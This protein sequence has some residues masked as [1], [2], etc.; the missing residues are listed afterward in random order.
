MALSDVIDDTTMDASD[1]QQIIGLLK[2]YSGF[3]DR[4]RLISYSN[5]SNYSLEVKNLDSGSKAVILYDSAGNV[6]LQANSSGV[7]LS[8]DGTNFGLTPATLSGTETLTNKTLTA[9]TITAPTF[10]RGTSTASAASLTLPTN[11]P[12]IPITGTTTITSITAQAAGKVVTL[13]FAS[14]GCQ[15]TNGSN[16]K[17]KGNYY[18]RVLGTLTLESD[19]TN[20][21]EVSRAG[22][23]RVLG[24]ATGTSGTDSTT[25]GTYTD[26]D[27]MSLTVTTQGG[28]LELDFGGSF[29]TTTD[30]PVIEVG[31]QI[32]G[33]TTVERAEVETLGDFWAF[34]SFKHTF[35][36]V[37]AGSHTVK[38]RWQVEGGATARSDGNR[39]MELREMRD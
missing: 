25:S 10:S 16:L 23:G 8:P 18:S 6:L 33:G 32:D 15:V 27:D 24:V 7:R 11:G 36:N 2:G 22:A 5:A 1:V 13:E 17:L 3:G 38:V 9:P 31:V 12:I 19:G 26:L 35:Q 34:V 28:D 30:G 21:I 4:V 14:A 39:R 20:W 37:A 29:D